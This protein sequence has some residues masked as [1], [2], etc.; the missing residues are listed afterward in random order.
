MIHAKA[1]GAAI[2][3]CFLANGGAADMLPSGAMWNCTLGS[4]LYGQSG[5]VTIQLTDS[6]GFAENSVSL[7]FSNGL[8]LTHILDGLSETEITFYD[9][10]GHGPAYDEPGYPELILAQTDDASAFSLSGGRSKNNARET[11]AMCTRTQ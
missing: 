2:A 8:V 6:E 9:G 7:T 10:D 1:A 3:L 11:F 5:D 4:P